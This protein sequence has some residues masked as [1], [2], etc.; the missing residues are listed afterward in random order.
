MHVGCSIVFQNPLGLSDEEVYASELRLS[1]L[2][3]PLGFDSLWTVEHHFTD[4]TMC[5]DPVQF[6]TCMAGT[7]QRASS[8]ARR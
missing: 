1:D 2:A 5:P 4:Y 3:E 7:H 8:S 6:L